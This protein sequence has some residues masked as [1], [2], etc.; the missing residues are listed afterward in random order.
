MMLGVIAGVHPYTDGLDIASTTSSNAI[1]LRLQQHRH[2][3]PSLRATPVATTDL[4]KAGWWTTLCEYIF[5][6]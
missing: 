1:P 5:G 6:W 4:A 3:G 2:R